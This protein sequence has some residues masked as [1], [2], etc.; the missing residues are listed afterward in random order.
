MDKE[1][2]QLQRSLSRSFGP[3]ET[4]LSV[5]PGYV[6]YLDIIHEYYPKVGSEG[7][8]GEETA[9]PQERQ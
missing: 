4:R 8:T 9:M 5:A 2:D 1:T 7:A 6:R 3:Q